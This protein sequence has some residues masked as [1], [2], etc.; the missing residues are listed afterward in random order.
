MVIASTKGRCGSA[1]GGAPDRSAS[2]ANDPTASVAL[3]PSQR[4]KGSGVPQKRSRLTAQSTLLASQ[5]P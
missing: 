2:S 4:Q 3:Q 5:S 1:I